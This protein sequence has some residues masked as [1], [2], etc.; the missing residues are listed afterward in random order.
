MKTNVRD[1]SIETYNREACAM[2]ESIRKKVMEYLYKYKCATRKMLA[3]SLNID[4][5]T[6]SGV[7]KQMINDDTLQDSDKKYPCGKT[8]RVVYWVS[9]K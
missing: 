8:G 1:S 6:M 7:V 3:D 2:G 5:A 9:I 4:T